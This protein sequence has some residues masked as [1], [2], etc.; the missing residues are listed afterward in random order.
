MFTTASIFRS[1]ND[2]ASDDDSDDG[3][4]LTSTLASQED[5]DNTYIVENILAERYFSDEDRMRYLVKWEGYPIERASWEPIDMFD[6]KNT[7]NEWKAMKERHENCGSSSPFDWEQWD[8][9]RYRER[10]D[11]D[12]RKAR[13]QRKRQ[14]LA[15]AGRATSSGGSRASSARSRHFVVSDEEIVASPEEETDLEVK[16]VPRR[17]RKKVRDSDEEEDSESADS[18]MEDLA[19]S[20]QRKRARAKSLKDTGAPES[21][22]QRLKDRRR[23]SLDDGEGED[24]EEHLFEDQPS[25]K[26]P[27][28]PQYGRPAKPGR[29]VSANKGNDLDKS[30]AATAS[31]LSM[32]DVQQRKAPAASV[33]SVGSSRTVINPANGTIPGVPRIGGFISLSQQNK[34]QKRGRNEPAPDINALELFHAGDPN[35]RITRPRK[36]STGGGMKVNAG[37]APQTKETVEPPER[38]ALQ[39]NEEDPRLQKRRRIEDGLKVQTLS[40]EGYTRRNQ[41]THGPETGRDAN[42]PLQGPIGDCEPAIVNDNETPISAGPSAAGEV[43]DPLASKNP[44]PTRQ[45]ISAK[46]MDIGPIK[47]LPVKP[48]FECILEVGSSSDVESI[49]VKFIGFSSAFTSFVDGLNDSRFWVS[50]FLEDAYITNFLVPELGVPFEFADMEMDLDKSQSFLNSIVVSHGAGVVLHEGFSLLIFQPSNDKLR[51]AFKTPMQQT[52]TALRAVAYPP[53]DVP[54]PIRNSIAESMVQIQKA[55]KPESMNGLYIHTLLERLL[56]VKFPEI[57]QNTKGGDNFIIYCP[58]IAHSE[59]E[60]METALKCLGRTSYSVDQIPSLYANKSTRE[61]VC[62]LV[63]FS[64]R[65]QLH[66]LP[67]IRHLKSREQQFYFFGARLE[68]SCSPGEMET[69]PVR[70]WN[71][72]TLI[73]LTPKFVLENEIAMNHVLNYQRIKAASTTLCFSGAMLAQAEAKVLEKPSSETEKALKYAWLLM[74]K[75]GRGEAFELQIQDADGCDEFETIA[76]AFAMYQLEHCAEYRRFMIGHSEDEGISTVKA[77]VYNCIEFHS[78]ESLVNEL[79]SKNF[80]QGNPPPRPPQ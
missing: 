54:I 76:D 28:F 36:I 56:G 62:V 30:V 12:A 8:E 53:F 25:S 64:L 21:K 79:V 46:M 45:T 27:P 23:R 19:K 39:K 41:A 33:S 37:E 18:L 2:I 71:F 31:K 60:E 9:D 58:E 48:T 59:A 61:K 1:Q 51:G 35:P 7:I 65:R 75:K 24:T 29:K 80:K 73:M 4:S 10:E 42:P 14:R 32:M 47:E 15:R 20:E 57:L 5:P 63:H 68:R 49:H 55:L 34:V 52:R 26:K 17:T 44:T 74:D 22:K 67:H 13:R 70:F 6:D 43:K 40:L 77:G 11:R 72:G 66:L 69:H 3:I 16:V 38:E 50:R 78:P